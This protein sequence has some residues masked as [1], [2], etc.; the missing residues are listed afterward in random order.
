MQQLLEQFGYCLS[1]QEPQGI[2]TSPPFRVG[3]FTFTTSIT[4][5]ELSTHPSTFIHISQYFSIILLPN[6]CIIDTPNFADWFR[7]FCCCCHETWEVVAENPLEVNPKHLS[8]YTEKVIQIKSVAFI[9]KDNDT[10]S[11]RAYF[12]F[13]NGND[14]QIVVFVSN[15]PVQF[16]QYLNESFLLLDECF[17][18]PSKSSQEEP[19]RI[20]AISD[21]AETLR[22]KGILNT[23]YSGEGNLL[24]QT[25]SAPDFL[26]KVDQLLRK[27]NDENSLFKICTD[28]LSGGLIPHYFSEWIKFQSE[29][30]IKLQPFESSCQC[31]FI[32]PPLSLSSSSSK[33]SF[34]LFKSQ[35]KATS[36]KCEAEKNFHGISTVTTMKSANR[37][38]EYQR[39]FGVDNGA[40]LFVYI[41]FCNGL[42]SFNYYSESLINNLLSQ[43]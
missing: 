8:E 41:L 43:K 31:L 32:L 30:L 39:Y 29:G 20:S 27:I 7:E 23:K 10:R 6:T 36:F 34:E 3:N 21:L 9:L 24:N 37:H 38:I 5:H 13:N 26:I 35:I 2:Q 16:V 19:S 42:R 15:D 1:L 4:F 28:S 22:K 18:T 14:V 40:N 11:C 17:F 12:A 25:L 33:T